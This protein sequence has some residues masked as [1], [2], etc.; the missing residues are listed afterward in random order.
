MRKPGKLR[1]FGELRL[2]TYPMEFLH[3][4]LLALAGKTTSPT[5]IIGPNPLSLNRA[6]PV[7]TH[8]H[9]M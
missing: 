1:K 3:G 9:Y 4:M 8:T 2:E 6:Y 5:T 7:V